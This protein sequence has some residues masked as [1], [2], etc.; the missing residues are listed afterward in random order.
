MHRKSKR[1]QIN[2][3]MPGRRYGINMR[4][5][6]RRTKR[7]RR[8]KNCY[9]ATAVYGS[10]EC[11][12]VWILRRFRDYTLTKTWYGRIFIKV[13]Y[14]ISPTIV[15]WFGSTNWFNNICRH[16]LDKMIINLQK[17]GIKNTPYNDKNP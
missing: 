13:Y 4:A 14:A 15:K 1:H 3:I 17:Q 16:T 12:Q 9:V 7:I 8:R 5:L 6:G 2:R 10:Y 11:P